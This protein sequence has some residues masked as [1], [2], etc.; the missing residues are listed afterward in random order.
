M[1][2]STR[3]PA[4]A[5]GIA[6]LG[7][8]MGNAFAAV[9]AEEAKQLG[10]TLTPF[11]AIKA[12]NADGSIPEYTGGLTKLPAGYKPGAMLVDPFADEKPILRINAA[13]M[14]QYGDKL[15]EGA[16]E[17]LRRN[18]EYYLNVYPT[19]RTATYPDEFLKR[20]ARNATQCTTVEEGLGLSSECKGGRPFPIP[21]TGYEVM[22]NKLTAWRGVATDAVQS[23]VYVTSDGKRIPTATTDMYR[24]YPYHFEGGASAGVYDRTR[25]FINAPIRQAGVAVMH[26]DYM[27]GEQYSSSR[28][29]WN[30]S[31]GQRRVRLAPEAAYDTPNAQSGGAL[32]YDESFLFSGKMDRFDFK[33]VGKREMF[34]PANSYK[35]QY[36]CSFDDL[37]RDRFVNPECERWELRRVWEVEATLKDGKRHVYSKR[38]Y[39]FDEDDYLGALYEAYDHGGKLARYAMMT[40]APVYD[41]KTGFAGVTLAYDFVKGLYFLSSKLHQPVKFHDQPKADR[42]LTPDALAGSGVR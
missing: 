3:W 20:T 39:Y 16:K 17:M 30:Y 24:D 40:N 6:M 1:T 19:H 13:N 4:F 41:R 36:E 8:V 28:R 9:S 5:A 34:I 21:K 10:T 18:P 26:W 38:H 7:T 29:S 42:E 33:L 22:W 2:K 37:I 23:G 11:G 27:N 32:L 31:P 14:A 35:L 25:A 15:S 12:G